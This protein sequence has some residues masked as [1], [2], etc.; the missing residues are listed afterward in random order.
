M[1]HLSANMKVGIVLQQLD[2]G[3]LKQ[4]LLLSS[5]RLTDDEVLGIRSAQ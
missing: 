5:A 1:E 4:L 3:A 2:E